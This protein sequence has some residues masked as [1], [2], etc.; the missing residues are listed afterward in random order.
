VFGLACL[1]SAAG[2]SE[3]A[4]QGPVPTG[5]GN[6]WS[7]RDGDRVALIGG[8]FIEREQ[9]YGYLETALTIA[10]PDKTI[11]FR[12]LGWSGDTVGGVS[13]SGFD[14]P[15]AGFKQLV[16]QVNAV[17]PTVIVVGYG[18][19]EAFAGEAGLD[20]FVKGYERLID[21][22]TPLKA[23]FLFLAPLRQENLGSPLPD[24][25]GHNEDLRRY[26]NAIRDLAKRRQVPFVTFDLIRNRGRAS[27]V[28]HLTD[29]GIHL[30]PMGYWAVAKTLAQPFTLN[31][32]FSDPD[33]G[34]VTLHDTRRVLGDAYERITR[35]DAMEKTS[36]GLRFTLKAGQLPMP[37]APGEPSTTINASR[38][39]KRTLTVE[40]L[41]QGRY[42]LE[43]DGHVVAT[44]PSSAWARGVEVADAQ[45][46]LEQV[47]KLRQTIIKKNELFFHR[48][49]P[50]NIT[51]LF[52]FRKHEQ[53][54]NAVEIP[55]FDPLVAERETL[56][57]ELKKPVPHA[58]EL[59]REDAKGVAR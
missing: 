58:Y 51:Y 11:T 46:E 27:G 37:P 47:E 35:L 8:T 16:D 57:A 29:N 25:A 10:N 38:V 12:N 1:I 7:F 44:A 59:I 14:P 20:A 17:K 26:S 5:G 23:R 9:R 43:I 31:V 28:V 36:R 52:G 34:K 55:R 21:A 22:L 15:E 33:V 50:Q 30:T 49:R 24:P 54:N 56:I 32:K 53:G 42:R 39:G 48:W 18:A 6:S 19:N 40:G 45:A 13:R 2:A 4:A 3:A 41:S